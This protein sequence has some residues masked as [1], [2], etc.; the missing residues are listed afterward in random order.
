MGFQS[1]VFSGCTFFDFELK[2]ANQTLQIA[3]P[4]TSFGDSLR[5][6]FPLLDQ[7]VNGKPLVYF[8]N[9]ATSQ[10]PQCVIDSLV[11]Y[12]STTNSNVHRGVHTLSAQAT[13]AYE[14]A[15]QKIA[16]FVNASDSN[17]IVHTRNASEAINLVAYSWG[18]KNLRP[19]D[20]VRSCCSLVSCNQSVFC[21]LVC[22]ADDITD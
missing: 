22:N 16:N 9:A 7:E 20:E 8:D 19:G 6:D 12:Y 10:K 5:Q 21:E 4:S 18:L 2:T 15:R 3:T 14:E 1:T 13:T 11:S 17:E